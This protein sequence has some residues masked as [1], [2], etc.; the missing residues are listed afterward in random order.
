MSTD[1]AIVIGHHPDAQGATLTVGDRR[2]T[3]FELCTPFAHELQTGLA[4]WGINSTVIQRPNEQPDQALADKVNATQADVAIELHFNA[5]ENPNAAGAEML[6]YPQSQ[7]GRALAKALLEETTDA[8]GNEPRGAK[9]RN[10]LPFLRLTDMPAV[11][12]EP[13]FG[14]NER[15]AWRLLTR[16]C[17]LLCAYRS[18]LV[19]F[20]QQQGATA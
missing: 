15:D 2:V 18:P 14:S 7:K 6:H 1:V 9:A 5:A 12:C 10:D 16:Q 20:V 11:I 17:D 19:D 8:L 3:E 13:A 4:A